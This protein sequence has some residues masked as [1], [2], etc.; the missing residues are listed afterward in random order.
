M[1]KLRRILVAIAD[2]DHTHT[3]V[4]R[5]A[6][7]L[8]HATGATL[9]LFHALTARG[10]QQRRVGGRQVS[11]TLTAEDSL[12]AARKAL[13]RI[14]TST[15][16][17]GCR[18]QT[19]VMTDVPA[20]AGIEQR[21]VA[22][23]ADLVISGT[24]SRRLADRLVLRHTDWELIRHCPVPLLLVKSNRAPR[25]AVVLAA[26]DPLH[27][28]AKPTRLD[29]RILDLAN[30][31]SVLLKAPLHAV[32]VYMP[33]SIMLAAGVRGTLSGNTVELDRQY[34][35]RVQREFNRESRTVAVSP[36]RRHLLLGSPAHELAQCAAQVRATL[37]VMGAVSRSR[38]G[39]LFIGST[40]EH[41]LDELAC[42]V[43]IVKPAAV[44][45]P[46]AARKSG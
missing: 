29:G 10:I 31:M 3:A 22:S 20:F 7:A 36:K 12:A 26:I 38:L 15:L 39:R 44:K 42:D 19:A 23:G 34:A 8:A 13:D 32:H 40:A 11:L 2:L 30:G 33:L 1:K 6:A 18:V 45:S 46:P 21:A 4:L 41:V 17:Q 5:R 43:L 9:E 25:K 27:A 16:L 14:A 24:R 35:A 28:N 37:V